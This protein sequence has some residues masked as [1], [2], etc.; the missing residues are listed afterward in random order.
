MDSARQR[1]KVCCQLLTVC[2]WRWL[3]YCTDLWRTIHVELF[4]FKGHV[5][6][7]QPNTIF[8][9]SLKEQGLKKKR[10]TFARKGKQMHSIATETV[11]DSF[12]T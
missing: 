6:L 11:I 8:Q 3:V 9:T 5:S 12:I 1:N 7:I 4:T 10:K 2:Q